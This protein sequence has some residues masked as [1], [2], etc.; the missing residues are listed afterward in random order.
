MFLQEKIMTNNLYRRIN[1]PVPLLQLDEQEEWANTIRQSIQSETLHQQ[2]PVTQLPKNFI[3]WFESYYPNIYIKTWEIFCT[4]PG[5][6]TA[7]HSDGWYPF[8]D[9]V[10]LN[11]EFDS[12]TSTMNWYTSNHMLPR[13]LNNIGTAQTLCDADDATKIFSS[14]VGQ[15]GLVNAGVLHNIDNTKN[16][17]WRWCLS[18]IPN[19][20]IPDA[21]RSVSTSRLLFQEAEIEF[22]E[23][24][25]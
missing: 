16:T 10:K 15:P 7:I 22:K 14:T 21:G 19:W 6:K 2:P 3:N 24:I 5:H 8:I 4:P 11:W 20:R 13:S 1:F 18:L 12:E 9:F 17:K 23:F 25:C